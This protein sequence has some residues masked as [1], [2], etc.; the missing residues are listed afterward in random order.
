M[1]RLGK[2]PRTQTPQT[3]NQRAGGTVILKQPGKKL[4]KV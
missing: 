3:K 4:K 1:E 2:D